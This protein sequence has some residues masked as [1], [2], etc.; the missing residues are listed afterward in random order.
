MDNILSATERGVALTRQ[1]LS[2][3][4]RHVAAPQIIDLRNEIPRMAGMLRA[5]L[6]GNIQMRIEV[7]E[8]VW[9]IEVDLAELEMA[10]LNI[11]VNARD[12]MPQGGSFT[13]DVR[14]AAREGG[15]LN[16]E[17]VAIALHDS[18]IGIPAAMLA[19][20]GK[21]FVQVEGNLARKNSGVGLG[22][23][24]ASALMKLMQG[25]LT[26]ESAAD[27]EPAADKDVVGQDGS[28][29]EHKLDSIRDM[30]AALRACWVPPPA[31]QARQHPY[32]QK[33]IG[34]ARD[35]T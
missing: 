11:A 2:F 1:L 10:L 15:T 7:A 31:E 24:I 25:K 26:I 23:A 5:S 3:S 30:F 8:Q 14:N 35:P 20:I 6:R 16:S 13:I 4:R 9:L 27:A 28:D 34:P 29:S 19:T 33:E 17:H 32:R 22:L 21:P 12:A 18:G